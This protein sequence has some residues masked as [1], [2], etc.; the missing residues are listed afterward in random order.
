MDYHLPSFTSTWVLHYFVLPVT[1]QEE[2][3]TI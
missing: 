2:E 3:E 1:I